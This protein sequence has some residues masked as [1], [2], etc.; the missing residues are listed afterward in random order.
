MD[1][2]LEDRIRRT[3][4]LIELKAPDCIIA[5]ACR[6]VA[7]RWEKLQAANYIGNETYQLSAASNHDAPDLDRLD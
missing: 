4:R 3:A 1:W 2:K 7:D 6:L 5:N